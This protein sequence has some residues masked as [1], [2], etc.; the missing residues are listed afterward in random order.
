M[1]GDMSDDARIVV[2]VDGSAP[3]QAALE[4][5]LEEAVLRHARL[6]VVHAWSFPFLAAAPGVGTIDQSTFEADANAVLDAALAAL[7]V[8]R[9]DASVHRL[10]VPGHPGEVLAE[11]SQEAALI[12]VGTR[13]H[14]T[15]VELV[16]GSIANHVV[17]HAACPVVIVPP[18]PD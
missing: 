5:A 1:L 7:D 17:H 2:G 15:L 18:P 10:V 3:S 16:L 12:V 8:G 11:R 13:G 4:W 9:L 6:E 14:S